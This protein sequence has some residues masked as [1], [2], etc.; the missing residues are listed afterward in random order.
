MHDA[1]QADEYLLT[2]DSE[3]YGPVV[4]AEISL[5]QSHLG[6]L[7]LKVLMQTEGE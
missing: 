6:D 2:F 3:T 5:I 1:Q 7:L 4:A